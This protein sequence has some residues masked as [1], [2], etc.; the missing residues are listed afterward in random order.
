MNAS[1]EL[2]LPWV[3]I[4]ELLLGQLDNVFDPIALAEGNGFD[5]WWCVGKRCWS[6]CYRKVGEAAQRRYPGDDR[7]EDNPTAEEFCVHDVH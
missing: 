7:G 2:L 1:A 5:R 6:R 3:A 4:T